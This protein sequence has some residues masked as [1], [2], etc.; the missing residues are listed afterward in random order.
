MSDIQEI[1]LTESRTLRDQYA[2]RTDVLDKVKALS[3]LPDGVH[4]TTDMVAAYYEVPVEAIESA[5]RRNP[6]ELYAN[7]RRV[8]KGSALREFETVNMTVSKRQALAVFPRRA[9]LN[10]GQILRDSEVAKAVRTYLLDVEEIAGPEVRNEAIERAAVARAQLAML[11]TAEG[12]TG[13]DR[14]WLKVKER[15]V[16]ARGLGEEPEVDPLDT[17]LYVPDFI[18]SQGVT[19]KRDIESIQ[20][21][22]GRRVAALYEAEYGEKP[23]K[24]ISELPNG[25]IRETFAWTQR[26]MPFFD[27]AW[28][29]WYAAEYAP[30]AELNLIEGGA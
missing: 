19:A 14:D 30:Q 15:A 7:G 26:H 20:S 8:L 6:E 29:R 21:W 22:F 18:R 25:Q 9:V 4:V 3:M 28:D 24:R 2:T 12:L 13:I 23:G 17:P 5:M 1:A 11:K 27:E 16:V 10:V